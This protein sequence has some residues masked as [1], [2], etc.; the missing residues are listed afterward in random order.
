MATDGDTGTGR[1]L[2]G[3]GREGGQER[4]KAKQNP[5][6]AIFLSCPILSPDSLK[7]NQS[8]RGRFVAP[9]H[10]RARARLKHR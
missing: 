7:L 2:Y 10:G 9:D 8:K 3:D 6:L 4:K 1:V 5:W